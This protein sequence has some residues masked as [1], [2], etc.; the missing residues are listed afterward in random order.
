VT[1]AGDAIWVAPA[2][3]VAKLT[4]PNVYGIV[5]YEVSIIGGT[6]AFQSATGSVN[7][8]GAV[9]LSTFRTVFRYTGQLWLG[10]P[11]H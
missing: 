4:A 1:E 10:T 9:D 2:E 8:I 11:A 7:S 6:G 3:A 5:S